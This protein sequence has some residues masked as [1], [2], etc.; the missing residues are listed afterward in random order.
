M[1]REFAELDGHDAY[2]LLG[3]A[4]DASAEEIRRAHI[5]GVRTH[6]PD[7]FQQEESRAEGAELT[8]LLNAARDILIK[9]RANYDAYRDRSGTE[10]EPELVD[11]PWDT[12]TEGR[13]PPPSPPPRS[14]PPPSPPRQ[15]VPHRRMPPPPRYG[16][17]GAW[18]PP[19]APPFR[20]VVPRVRVLPRV[21]IA[22]TITLVACTALLTIT[23]ALLELLPDP[24]DPKAEVPARLAGTWRGTIKDRPA[25]END[26]GWRAEL[27]L[28]EGKHNGEV[29][30]LGGRCSG[31][32]VPI[33]VNGATLTLDTRFPEGRAGCDVGDVNLTPGRKGKAEFV[34]YS[35]G[36]ISA[37]GTLTRA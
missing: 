33:S 37:K 31:T 11:D 22:L 17:P 26:D 18:P 20:P 5:A 16:M 10:E 1:R 12:A 15:D 6:H 29:R 24:S 23:T 13:P 25:R 36:E 28:R 21:A 9:D 32:A 14:Q 2:E 30:Y 35:S 8:R 34:I 19:P 4:P 27:V 7:R 3:V